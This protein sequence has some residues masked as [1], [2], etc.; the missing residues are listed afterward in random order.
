MELFCSPN[1]TKILEKVAVP[2]IAWRTKK[3]GELL[4]IAR[5][6]LTKEAKAWFY[7]MN[8]RVVPFMH[9]STLYKDRA[10]LLYTILRKYKFNVGN[11]IQQSLLEED[12]RRSLTH[13]H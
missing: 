5:G 1:Y 13:P 10:I 6:S 3:G 9:V 11:I 8:S 12:T 2:N 7:F 4:D